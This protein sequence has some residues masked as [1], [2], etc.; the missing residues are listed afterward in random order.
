MSRFF[1]G[2]YVSFPI[3]ETLAVLKTGETN[4]V[5]RKNITE[6]TE[7]TLGSVKKFKDIIEFAAVVISDELITWA[8]PKTA[9]PVA[10]ANEPTLKDKLS[11]QATK[12]GKDVLGKAI[13]AASEKI[14]SMVKGDNP[15]PPD[16]AAPDTP[17]EKP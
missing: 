7:E 8:E 14:D 12:L 15:P 11:E 5:G 1:S 2:D 9:G 17:A 16:K 6:I 13:D 4:T 10:Q 3:G